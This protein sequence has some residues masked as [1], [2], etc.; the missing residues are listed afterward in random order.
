MG[1]RTLFGSEMRIA[2]R[3][4]VLMPE[5]AQPRQPVRRHSHCTLSSTRVEFQP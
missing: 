5:H 3:G 4:E 2:I 1:S